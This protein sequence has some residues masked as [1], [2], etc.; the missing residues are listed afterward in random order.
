MDAAE[1]FAEAAG[2]IREGAAWTDSELERLRAERTA[3]NTEAKAA[4]ARLHAD[5]MAKRESINAQIRALV[6]GR[7]RYDKLLRILDA[8]TEASP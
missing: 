8:E 4:A 3:L 7:A 1:R 6:A 2:G 5:T